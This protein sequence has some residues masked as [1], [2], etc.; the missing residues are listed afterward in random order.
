MQPPTTGRVVVAVEPRLY[1][2]T[3]VRALTA[4]DL[5]VTLYLDGGHLRVSGD[6][7]D[8]ALVSG[9]LPS[10]LD[11]E[12]VVR[13]PSGADG[14]GSAMVEVGEDRRSFRVD[15]PGDVAALVRELLAAG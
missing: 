1:G 15:G 3:L 2:D 13:L 14:A 6:G 9:T 10:D 4:H 7:Y 11:A 5:D 8:V 12:V